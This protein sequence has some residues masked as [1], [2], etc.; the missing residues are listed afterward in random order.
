MLWFYFNLCAS[1]FPPCSISFILY[2]FFSLKKIIFS[3]PLIFFI[4]MC[5]W[6][7]R[8][9]ILITLFVIS[10]YCYTIYICL[11]L[12][13][14][15]GVVKYIKYF[16]QQIGI[17]RS[18]SKDSIYSHSIGKVLL[19]EFLGISRCSSQLTRTSPHSVRTVVMMRVMH[20]ANSSGM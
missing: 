17:W 20:L 14:F 10:L 18:K 7:E 15:L 5:S 12:P 8:L 6:K 1:N 4:L 16:A 19:V 13:F 3:L 11:A 2:F 9:G